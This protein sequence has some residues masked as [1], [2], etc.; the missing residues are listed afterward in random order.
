ME[1]CE[2]NVDMGTETEGEQEVRSQELEKRGGCYWEG[3]SAFLC[4]THQIEISSGLCVVKSITK[5]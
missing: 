1:K 5:G 4:R 2:G 3:K